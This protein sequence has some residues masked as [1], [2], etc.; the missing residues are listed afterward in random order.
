MEYTTPNP[1]RKANG[2]ASGLNNGH[3]PPLNGGAAPKDAHR[4]RAFQRDLPEVLRVITQRL[5]VLENNKT[6][7]ATGWGRGPRPEI[8]KEIDRLVRIRLGT[9]LKIFRNSERRVWGGVHGYVRQCRETAALVDRL[10]RIEHRILALH[11][12]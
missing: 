12:L 5:T 11:L 7:F 6:G 3:A 2:H 9:Q 8:A 1:W 4:R 10:D